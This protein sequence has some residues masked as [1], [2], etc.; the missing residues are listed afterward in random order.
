MTFGAVHCCYSKQASKKST[1]ALSPAAFLSPALVPV[2][3][4]VRSNR[5]RGPN[6]ADREDKAQREFQRGRCGGGWTVRMRD[7][8]GVPAKDSLGRKETRH[9]WNATGS[10]QIIGVETQSR[11]Q[12][13]SGTA[14]GY[15]R[16][17][18]GSFNT[19]TSFLSKRADYQSESAAGCAP[20][21]VSPAEV[22][23]DPEAACRQA[24]EQGLVEQ[25]R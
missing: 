23:Q 25:I 11:M 8:Q 12:Q 14:H 5:E 6:R 15:G 1:E 19:P 2:R 24:T 21:K 9:H 7:G 22:E 20:R 17:E 3:Q 13:L 16:G 18:G 4:N 10:G